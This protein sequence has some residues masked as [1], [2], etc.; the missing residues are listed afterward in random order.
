[1]DQLE[2]LAGLDWPLI[3]NHVVTLGLAY[4]LALPIAYNREVE[5]RSAGLRTFPIV[6][7]AAC[8]FSLL[9][10]EV[11]GDDGGSSRVAQ[12]IIAGIGF[13]GGGSIL[14]SD[15]GVMGTAT[16]ASIWAVGAIGIAVAWHRLEIAIS[17]SVLTFATL[18]VVGRFKPHH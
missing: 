2:E 12:G 1:M 11:L 14:K 13:I 5:E 8:G 18:A 9:G 4:L 6:A 15:S 10:L 7:I 3:I 17:I 16:A